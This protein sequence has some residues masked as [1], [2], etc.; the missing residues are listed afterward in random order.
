MAAGRTGLVELASLRPLM[1]RACQRLNWGFESETEQ[2]ETD[3]LCSINL[4]HGEARNGR[5]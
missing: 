4:G 2:T 5:V 1:K 3:F